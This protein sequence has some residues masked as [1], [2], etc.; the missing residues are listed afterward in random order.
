[1]IHY[2]EIKDAIKNA[3]AESMTDIVSSTAQATKRALKE[4]LDE[5]VD[6]HARLEDIPKFKRKLNEDQF[7]HSKEMERINTV[8]Q[9]I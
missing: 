4:D 7:K 5:T 8:Y 2:Q 9:H 1:M 3:I 6:K